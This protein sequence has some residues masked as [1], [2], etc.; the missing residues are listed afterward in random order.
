[1]HFSYFI[2]IAAL[3]ETALAAGP[4]PFHRIAGHRPA[5]AIDVVTRVT[6][7]VSASCTPTYYPA[8]VNN[9]SDRVSLT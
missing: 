5:V 6:T 9:T 7:T 3:L 8:I 4:S 1:M 2:S